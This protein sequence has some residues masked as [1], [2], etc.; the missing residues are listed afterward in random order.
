M[1]HHKYFLLFWTSVHHGSYNPTSIFYLH[2]PTPGILHPQIHCWSEVVKQCPMSQMPISFQYGPAV[3]YCQS[4]LCFLSC[5]FIQASCYGTAGCLWGWQH[6]R[7]RMHNE[8]NQRPDQHHC[9]ANIS[10][11][12]H[13]VLHLISTV[14]TVRLELVCVSEDVLGDEEQ[15]LVRQR[16]SA[17][18]EHFWTHELSHILE[19]ISKSCLQECGVFFFFN[20]QGTRTINNYFDPKF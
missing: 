10:P 13:C 14:H 5:C 1:P 19:L 15:Y 18:T 12:L 6:E 16:L 9:P 17:N 2:A 8:G 7:V 4:T 11:S 20:S 3:F